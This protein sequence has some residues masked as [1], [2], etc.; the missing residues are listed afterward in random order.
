T[1]RPCS[2]PPRRRRVAGAPVFVASLG[3][4]MGVAGGGESRWGGAAQ[5]A[6]LTGESAR[7]G[8]PAGRRRVEKLSADSGDHRLKTQKRGAWPISLQE[9][10]TAIE[11]ALNPANRHRSQG[12]P[13]GSS[14]LQPTLACFGT[15]ATAPDP[16]SSRQRRLSC[17]AMSGG[18]AQSI[19]I[20][21]LWPIR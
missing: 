18:Q 19:A 10:S 11:R 14:P 2:A 1:R 3:S 16:S 21:L 9:R 12:V 7:N 5:V 4:A 20:G 17:P 13:S 8:G 15:M 6:V